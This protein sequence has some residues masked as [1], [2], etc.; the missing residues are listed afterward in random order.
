MQ[1]TQNQ[2][3]SAER[4]GN[5]GSTITKNAKKSQNR[6]KASKPAAQTKSSEPA[7]PEL[8]V[9]PSTQSK[10]PE[11]GSTESKVPSAKKRPDDLPTGVKLEAIDE[12]KAAEEKKAKKYVRGV[13]RT[14]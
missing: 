4:G 14:L 10:T 11:N 6:P 2:P 1:A 3:K 13:C 8:K 5:S 9:Q 7:S 12:K